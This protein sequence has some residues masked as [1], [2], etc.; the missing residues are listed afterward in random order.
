MYKL[1]GALASPYSMKMRAVLRYRR[2][3]FTWHDGKERQEALQQVRAPV[4]P[5]LEFPD[6][7]FA[8]DSTPLI[9]ALENLHSKRS[10]VPT[11]PAMSFLA[12]MLEDFADEWLTKAMFGYRWLADVDQVQMS[13]WLAFDM[14]HGGGLEA[15]QAAGEA[16]RQRQ[17]GRMAI[18]GCTPENFPLIEASTR[19]VLQALEDHVTDRFFLFG[20]RPSLAEFG[21]LGQLSQLAVDPTPQAMMRADYPYT[22]RW[23][24]HLDDLSGVEGDWAEEP[25]E[26]ALAIARVAGEVYAPFLAANAAALEAGKETFA[27][28]A[29]GKPYSQGTFK[30]QA[31]C[32]LDLRARYA[33]LDDNDRARAAGWI[34]PAW[35]ALLD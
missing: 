8:N 34:G 23:L 33:A 25:S 13:R 35:Q 4:I 21:L 9:Y 7:H 10:I 29:M 1:Y 15:S 24:T 12:H 11:D 32:I 18:V 2:L 28:E 14:M 17:V 5:V 6:G 22:Y 3:P 16:F 26:A 30:Y 27:I 31:K 20:S 19:A